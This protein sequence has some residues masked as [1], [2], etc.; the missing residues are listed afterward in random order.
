M[1][2]DEACASGALLVRAN[3]GDTAAFATLVRTHQRLVHSLALR[4]LADRQQA[5]DLAQEVFLQLY[6]SLGSLESE[7]HLKFWLRRVTMHRAIDRL[8][9]EPKLPVAPLAEAEIVASES[10]DGDPL[11]ERRLRALVAELPPAARAVV[12]LR[13]QEDLDPLEIAQT[14]RMPVNTVKSRLKRSLAEL[15]ERMTAAAGAVP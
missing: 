7:E 13:Y 15:R 6:R 8:R 9:R 5:E 12:L 3:A 1:S 2:G 14:L 10:V 4:M 11:L